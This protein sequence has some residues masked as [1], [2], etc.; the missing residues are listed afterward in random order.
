MDDEP[1]LK[2]HRRDDRTLRLRCNFDLTDATVFF[3]VKRDPLDPDDEALINK[4]ITVHDLLGAELSRTH[5]DLTKDDTNIAHGRYWYDFQ[6]KDAAGK[7]SS[8][9]PQNLLVDQDIRIG[10]T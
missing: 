2:L 4:T 3:T 5:V 7:I 6:V 10:T 8:T 9:G 1:I